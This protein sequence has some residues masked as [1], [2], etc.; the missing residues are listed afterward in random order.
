MNSWS[1]GECKRKGQLVRQIPQDNVWASSLWVSRSGEVFRRR[2]NTTLKRWRWDPTPHLL[3]LDDETGRMG[4]ILEWWVPLQTAMAMA[5]RRRAHGSTARARLEEGRPLKARYVSWGEEE[6]DDDTHWEG[7]KWKPLS[8]RCG[9]VPCDG[10]GYELS[11]LGRL[12]N[13][14]GKVT[15]GFSDGGTRWGA[16]RGAGLVDLLTAAKLQPKPSPPPSIKLALD[17]LLTR[18]TPQALCDV[19]GI[20][21]ETAWSYFSRAATFATPKRLSSRWRNIVDP[22]LQAALHQLRGDPCLGGPLTD[23]M[24]A[25]TSILPQNSSFHAADCPMGQLRFARLCMAST[26]IV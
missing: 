12:K 15:R 13:K 7:E 14:E 9:V 11:N 1:D 5:W 3:T 18:N 10:L 16:V 22:D 21:I 26:G 19:T 4:V 20:S 23:L 2:Y 24:E 25:V 17:A 8:W 6:E